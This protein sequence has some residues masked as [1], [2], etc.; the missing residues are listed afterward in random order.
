MEG[1]ETDVAAAGFQGGLL[2]MIM[3]SGPVV[4]LVLLILILQSLWSWT[5]TISKTL[6]LRKANSQSREFQAVFWENRNLARADDTS[7]RLADSYLAQL[8]TAGYREL[9]HLIHQQQAGG[10]RI[11]VDE[12][13]NVRR[14]MERA[15]LD[16]VSKLES[17]VTFLATTASA[18]PF[19][20]LFG[21]VWGIM[22]AFH[23]LGS[24][25]MSTIQAVAPGISEALVATAVGLAAAIP[26]A[27]AFNYFTV[28][29]RQ[30]RESMRRFHEEFLTIAR[31]DFTDGY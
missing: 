20:G 6:Q 17:G 2:E 12:L 4:K 25:Q 10:K 1:I 18:A 23:G 7:R 28:A 24:A 29:I 13:E 5:V 19:I 16:E 30:A 22:G 9:S 14:A 11:T 27:I 3:Q 21:T 15:E 26:A 31:S 8:F